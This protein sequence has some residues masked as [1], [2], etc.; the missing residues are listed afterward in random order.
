MASTLK[1]HSKKIALA[2]QLIKTASKTKVKR[3]KGRKAK[4][5][6]E[7]ENPHYSTYKHF[8][9]DSKN[10]FLT[11]FKHIFYSSILQIY[12]FNIFEESI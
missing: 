10:N 4:E 1:K 12:E 8:R 3:V 9:K 11:F 5:N 2:K 6:Q 7:T